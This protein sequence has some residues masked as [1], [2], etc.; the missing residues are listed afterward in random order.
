M[1]AFLQTDPGTESLDGPQFATVNGSG[2]KA[3]FL[4]GGRRLIA[5]LKTLNRDPKDQTTRVLRERLSQEDAPIVFGSLGV[6]KVIEGLHDHDKVS[7]QIIDLAGRAVRRHLKKANDQ[8]G[9]S[10]ERLSLPNA[11]GLVI[12]MN[13]SEPMIDAAAIGYAIKSAFDA[14]GSGYPHITNVWACIESHRIR[15]QGGREGYPQIHVFTSLE[16]QPELDFMGRMLGA[17]G[18]ANGARVERL[19][20][21]GDWDVMRPIYDG[22]PPTIELS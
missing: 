8:I 14:G 4:L 12:L 7:K 17:W 16:R 21:R 20:H 18:S 2:A 5:E 1:T 6:S 3:D 13:D 19:E 10:K 15:M 11:G 9:A 22:P